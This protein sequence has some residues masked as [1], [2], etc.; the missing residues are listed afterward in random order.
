MSVCVLLYS[1]S[2]GVGRTGTLIT[3]DWVL[4]QLLKER[5]VDVAGTIKI[6]RS[7]RMKMV[8]T[9]VSMHIATVTFVQPVFMLFCDVCMYD[10]SG[11]FVCLY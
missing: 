2:A 5:L 10:C 6:L 3:I 9:L 7:Q 11:E 8:Q 4:E 1:P